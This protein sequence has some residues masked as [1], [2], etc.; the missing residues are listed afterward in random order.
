MTGSYLPHRICSSEGGQEA[1]QEESPRP[2]KYL[3][4]P[5]DPATKST[6]KAEPV[7]GGHE[8]GEMGRGRRQ[9]CV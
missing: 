7:G 8:P 2:I 6:A 3:P 9:I 4:H 5:P 1:A